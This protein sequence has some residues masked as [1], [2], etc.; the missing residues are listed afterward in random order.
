MLGMTSHHIIEQNRFITSLRWYICNYCRGF[1][2]IFT[3]NSNN[4]AEDVCYV[5]KL[6]GVEAG[7]LLGD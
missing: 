1:L 4:M 7:R 6:I 5:D 2:H 3:I